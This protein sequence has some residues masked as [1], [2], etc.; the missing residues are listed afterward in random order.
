MIIANQSATNFKKGYT[1]VYIPINL[2]NHY[3]TK[4]IRNF[5][6]MSNIYIK[7][8]N[9]LTL[10]EIV[11]NVNKQLKEALLPNNIIQIIANANNLVS[12]SKYTP[13]IIKKLTAIITSKIIYNNYYTNNLSNLGIIKFSNNISNYIQSVDCYMN[14]RIVAKILCS[15]ITFNDTTTFSIFKDIH[16]TKFEKALYEQF[17]KDNLILKK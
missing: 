11:E 10:E 1:N 2:R 7:T 15:V 12:S 4:T 14:M 17:Y 5:S 6:L 9:N 16:D 3:K 8:E 13:L